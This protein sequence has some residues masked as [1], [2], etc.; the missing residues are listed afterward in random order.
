MLPVTLSEN[1]HD[2]PG[3]RLAPATL[4]FAPPASA[5]TVPHVSVNPVGFAICNPAGKVSV[6]A[7]P[8][9]VLVFA[10]LIVKLSVVLL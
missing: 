4:K 10:L 3:V 1:V 6:N 8:V 5:V 2:P 9:R 7:M